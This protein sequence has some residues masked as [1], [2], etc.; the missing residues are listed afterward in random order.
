M[1]NR[2]AA[3]AR[4]ESLLQ[5][6]YLRLRRLAFAL[7]LS[8]TLDADK[9]YACVTQSFVRAGNRIRRK[10]FSETSILPRL[11][12]ALPCESRSGKGF[13]GKPAALASL[14]KD[15]RSVWALIRVARMDEEEAFATL[16]MDKSSGAESL[17][18]ADAAMNPQDALDFASELDNMT[19]RHEIWNTVSF[20]LQQQ[21]RTTRYV[22]LAFTAILGI[23]VLLLL[24]REAYLGIKI[25]SFPSP[26][27]QE[28]LADSIDSPEYYKN[29]SEHMSKEQPRISTALA[30][31]LEGLE[32]EQL[33]RAA[34][35]FYDDKLMRGVLREGETLLSMHTMMYDMGLS[36]GKAHRLMA[37]AISMYYANYERPFMP[38]ERT[39]DFSSSFESI[40]DAAVSLALDSGFSGT[41]NAHP[42]I[43]AS[44]E[45]FDSYLY[46]KR[47]L[48]V[49][50]PVSDLLLIEKELTPELREEY[51]KLIF[52]FDNPLGLNGS[53]STDSFY[54]TSDQTDHFYTLRE[55]LGKEFY[56]RNLAECLELLP[57]ALVS[58]D[59]LE[60]NESSL[61]S[62]TLSKKDILALAKN[63][64]RFVFLGI[65]SPYYQGYPERIEHALADMADKKLF[66]RYDV[67]QIDEEYM[68]YSINYAAPLRLPQGFIDELRQTRAC[69]DTQ[70]EVLLQ[71]NYH[72]RFAHPQTRSGYGLL[73]ALYSNPS[74]QF[75][76]TQFKPFSKMASF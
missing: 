29:F 66:A 18:R 7:A 35:R 45:S 75:T 46:S 15:A 2:T 6:V 52:A 13:S 5:E 67:F 19:Q 41:F 28:V 14:D 62:A 60:G 4:S 38:G 64:P 76:S 58:S 73:R 51:E 25:I 21:M 54:Y 30:A 61:F 65:A 40:Y 23:A 22:R 10:S 71:Y 9:A 72:M 59:I 44:R 1:K 16:H 47:F 27:T 31:R 34:F 69:K 33:I 53:L 55:A 49:V 43:F 3:V 20:T 48:S 37:N 68:L 26:K 74:L 8:N 12:R 50:Y 36:Y 24:S 42:E 63:D 17:S 57:D 56:E 70:Y 32:D 39:T 11:L